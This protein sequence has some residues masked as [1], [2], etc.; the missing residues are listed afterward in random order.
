MGRIKIALLLMIA[1]IVLLQ[2]PPAIS[3]P[4]DHL[5]PE[6]GVYGFLM[7]NPYHESVSER[8]LSDDK[9][10][11]CQAVIITSFKTETAVYIKY[12]DKK[13]ASLPV[14]VSLKL[15]HPLWIQLNEYFE[16]NKGNLT[17]EI[18][19][20]KALSRIKSKVTRQEAEIE[21]ETAKLL[22]AVWATALSQV[23]YEDKENQGLDGERI[24][25]ANFTLGVG[26]RAGKAWSPDEGTI[27]SELAE[28]AKALREYPMLS[29]AKRKTASKT[30]QS[31]AQVLLARLKTNK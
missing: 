8:L 26:Y 18:A 29:G 22:E 27:T 12:D 1:M 11:I 6:E 25:Y 20:K 15:V 3:G 23:K 10:R 31:K 7:L 30:M 16:K 5:K 24:H 13:P 14:V 21:S 28:L 17:D 4:G 19:Q 2:T 9:Y